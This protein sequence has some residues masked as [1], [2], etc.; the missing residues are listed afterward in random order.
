MMCEFEAQEFYDLGKKLVQTNN[1]EAGY[2]TAIGRIYYACHLIGLDAIVNKGWYNSRE[3]SEDHSGVCR[4]LKQHQKDALADQ[5][6]E[7]Y[8]FREHSDYH[9]R[10]CVQGKCTHCDN[11]GEGVNLVNAS[12][13]RRAEEIA[14]HI[15]PRLRAIDPRKSAG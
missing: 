14:T 15:L 6:L 1:D 11:V 9:I 12:S 8:R 5:L 10:R 13:W 2:R 7:L 3:G 4:I